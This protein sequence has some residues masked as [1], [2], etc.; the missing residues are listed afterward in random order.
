[1][2]GRA[3]RRKLLQGGRNRRAQQ[4]VEFVKGNKPDALVQPK[5][6][7]WFFLFPS[8]GFNTITLRLTGRYEALPFSHPSL[9]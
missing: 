6:H 8:L 4:L 7:P 5:L 2:V 3:R 9:L 1:M